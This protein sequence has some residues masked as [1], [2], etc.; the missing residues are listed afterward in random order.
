[1]L[2]LS[3]QGTENSNQGVW[4]MVMSAWLYQKDNVAQMEGPTWITL[5][6]T[7]GCSGPGEQILTALRELGDPL[8]GSSLVL[9]DSVII[10]YSDPSSFSDP[11][12]AVFL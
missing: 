7:V 4:D 11:F 6:R 12:S 1:M 5:N 8:I 2:N 10:H 9:S 3:S